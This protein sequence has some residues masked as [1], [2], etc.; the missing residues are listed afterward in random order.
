[1]ADFLPKAATSGSDRQP[2][3]ADGFDLSRWPNGARNTFEAESPLH[4]ARRTGRLVGR[5]SAG[6]RLGGRR[7]GENQFWAERGSD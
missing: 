5:A 4:L 2:R 3:A 7:L 1:M 6:R